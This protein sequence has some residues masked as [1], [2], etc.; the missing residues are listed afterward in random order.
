VSNPLVS[1][2]TSSYNQGQLLEETI[3]SV[4]GQDYPHVEYII[5]DGGLSDNSIDIIKKYEHRLAYWVSKSD[6][7]S[8]TR[9]TK[10]GSARAVSLSPTSIR[11]IRMNRVRCARRSIICHSI[12]PSE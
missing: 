6:G 3:R 2:I 4:L 1:I 12:P 9:S 11:M 8:R 7:G 10:A 5:I